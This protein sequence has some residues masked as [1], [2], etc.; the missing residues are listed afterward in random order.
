MPE[1]GAESQIASGYD[2]EGDVI[3]LLEMK[4][5]CYESDYGMLEKI[6]LE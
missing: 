3:I 1:E 2:V 5:L 6:P 4:M